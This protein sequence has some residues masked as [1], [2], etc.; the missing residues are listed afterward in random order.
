VAAV[1]SPEV[2]VV[3]THYDAP[4]RLALVLAGLAAQTLPPRRFEVVVADDGSPEPPRLP[5]QPYP[6]RLVRQEDDGFRAAA[7]RNLGAAA[8]TGRVLC[9]LD[10]DTVPEPGYLAA[11]LDAL[12]RTAAAD[13]REPGGTGEALVV[14]RRRHAELSGWTPDRLVAWFA[15][16]A[17]PPVELEEPAWLLDGFRWT[18]DL[19]A[20]DDESYRF[21]IAAVLSMHRSL[22]E[23]VGGFEGSFRAYGGEDWEIA[24]RCWLAGAQMRYVAQAVAWHDGVDFAGRE[25]D[26]RAVQNRQ[27]ATLATLLPSPATRPPGP[28]WEHPLV[29][30]EVDDRGWTD[31]QALLAVAS[32]LRAGDVGVWLRDGSVATAPAPLAADPRVHVGDVPP[33]VLR[34]CRGRVRVTAA[35]ELV[36]PLQQL[37]ARAPVDVPGLR[38]RQARDLARHGWDGTDGHAGPAEAVRPVPPDVALGGLLRAR[39][40]GR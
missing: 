8:T 2:S 40:E 21:V 32:L 5:A 12:D 22:F 23:R 19:R 17:G 26:R 9:F 36:Q 6:L 4:D 10:G 15:G 20:A 28:V 24:N 37:L 11:V 33:A 3:V 1:T 14:G 31:E 16:R 25:V 27:A 29:V 39:A 13:R 38:V 35:V 18:D 30:V 7:A 34:R